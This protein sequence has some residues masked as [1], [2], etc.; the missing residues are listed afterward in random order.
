MS[1][2]KKYLTISVL[3]LTMFSHVHAGLSEALTAFGVVCA[4]TVMELTKTSA[5]EKRQQWIKFVN[6]E[7]EKLDAAIKAQ[8]KKNVQERQRR[9]QEAWIKYFPEACQKAADSNNSSA[10]T[11]A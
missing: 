10:P 6:E 4:F 11:F 3:S 5:D 8:I 1:T 9:E 2:L 7:N